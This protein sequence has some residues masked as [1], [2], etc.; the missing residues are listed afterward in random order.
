MGEGSSA[1]D[2]LAV[3]VAT[4][5]EDRWQDMAME[6][7]V[8]S[9]WAQTSAPDEILIEHA[10]DHGVEYARNAG[11]WKADSAWLVFL[12]ADD[13]LDPAYVAAIRDAIG[14]DSGDRLL[15]PALRDLDAESGRILQAARLPN[16]QA[17][18]TE[19]NHCCIGTAVPRLLFHTVGGFRE[20]YEPWEDWEL[21]LR[22]IRAGARIQDVP[23]AIYR[24]R[25]R[26][27]SR[28]RSLTRSAALELHGRISREHAEGLA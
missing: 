8:P 6:W 17:P 28:H 23:E 26:P 22:C 15:A 7:A 27:G 14:G 11:A 25:V 19:L 1:Q 21:W 3:I 9:V 13:Q 4:C 5:G 20:G 18:M 10:P 12:D 24:A 2:S 16:R